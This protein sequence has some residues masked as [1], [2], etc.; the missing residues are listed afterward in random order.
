MAK[1]GSACTL[2]RGR[3]CRR[4]LVLLDLLLGLDRGELLGVACIGAI[5]DA[6]S[7]KDHLER[8]LNR[9]T[10]DEPTF[11]DP[12]HRQLYLAAGILKSKEKVL[13]GPV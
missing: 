6:V 1:T 7:Q 8:N 10:T 2:K 13:V 5:R 11:A 12:S 4:H 3:R 9:K